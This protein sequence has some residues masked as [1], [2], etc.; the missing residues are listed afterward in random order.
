MRNNLIRVNDN[1]NLKIETRL[2]IN[3][4]SEAMYWS[5]FL[6]NDNEKEVIIQGGK[7][8]YEGE[9]IYDA[10]DSYFD[11]V[12]CKNKIKEYAKTH[13]WGD[14]TFI[15]DE[16]NE[17]NYYMTYDVPF[18][19]KTYYLYAGYYELFVTSYELLPPFMYQFHSTDFNELME[20]RLDHF[21]SD[22][23]TFFTPDL[24][25]EC[26]AF[27]YFDPTGLDEKVI[28]GFNEINFRNFE[29]KKE[30]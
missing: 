23:H 10:T 16:Y 18:T 13:E 11:T 19:G 9:V 22:D 28:E 20:Y 4:S 2:N 14:V 8:S 30:R 21:C 26:Y 24:Q 7:A 17:I 25:Q 15:H 6:T 29:N 12:L 27:N 3:E 1:H 5:V